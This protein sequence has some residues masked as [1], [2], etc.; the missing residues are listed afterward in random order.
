MHQRSTYVQH[1]FLPYTSFAPLPMYCSKWVLLLNTNWPICFTWK[2]LQNEKQ[3]A[4]LTK[5]C[6]DF[7]GK[8]IHGLG[9]KEITELVKLLEL[10]AKPHALSRCWNFID[11]VHQKG[12]NFYLV[13][14]DE[15][16]SSPVK[17]ESFYCF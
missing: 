10:D 2:N 5:W 7:F 3:S 11:W 9:E 12:V 16:R 15:C 6:H 8:N 4:V 14:E 17:L 1:M 13:L